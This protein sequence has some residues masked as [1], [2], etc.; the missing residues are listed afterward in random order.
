MKSWS[1]LAQE[2]VVLVDYH[3]LHTKVCVDVCMSKVVHGW[4]RVLLLLFM[5]FG[6]SFKVNSDP[7]RS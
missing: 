7:K 6:L 4:I 3:T 5:I 1:R 2:S